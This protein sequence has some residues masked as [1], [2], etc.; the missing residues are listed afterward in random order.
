[1]SRPCFSPLLLSLLL[2]QALSPALAQAPDANPV[3]S[4]D[5]AFGLSVGRET[6]GLYNSGSVRGF[7][8]SAAG[9]LRIDG[10]YFDQVWGLS[11]RV[12]TAT[13]IRVGL[14]AQGFAFP[15]PT[16]I[17]DY[18]LRRPTASPSVALSAGVDDFGSSYLDVDASTPLS[19]ELAAT[20]GLSVSRTG[21]FNGTKG[22]GWTGGLGLW[23]RPS[24]STE[25]GVFASRARAY[26]D[27][28][29]P[30]LIPVGPQL[31]PR[32]RPFQFSGPSWADYEGVGINRGVLLRQRLSPSWA[33]RAGL[34]RSEERGQSSYSH[35]LLDVQADGSG[36]RLIVA[37]PP[38]LVAATSGEIRAVGNWAGAALQHQLQLSVNG[39][40]R[41]RRN[42]GSD[43]RDFGAA[44]IGHDFEPLEPNWAFGPQTQDAVRQWTAGSSYQLRWR[45][46]AEV[47]LGLQQTHYRKAVERPSTARVSTQDAPLLFNLSGAWYFNEAIALYA[48]STRGLEESGTAPDNASNRRQALPAIRTRQVDAG[49]RWQLQPQLKLVAGL[50]EVRKPYLNLDASNTFT[51]LGEVRHRGAELSLSG[52]LTPQLHLVAGAVLMQPRVEGEAVRLGRVGPR[53]V[54]QPE[55]NLRLNLSWQPRD[56]G[57]ASLDFGASHTSELPATRDNR[58]NIPGI[59]V[60]DAGLRWPLRWGE[61][62]VSARFAVSNLFNQRGFEL[63]GSGAYA[64]RPGRQASLSLS[65]AF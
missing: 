2:A 33:L 41:D 20:A 59:T 5:D 57:G 43:S 31:P 53:P 42:G 56:W 23:W 13:T 16:G 25:L 8:P 60:M 55:R 37:D 49:L 45:R 10:L 39:R 44:R 28:F 18:A 46:Q 35:L 47:L 9:N 4:A 17:V 15:A 22:K 26:D 65:T 30:V 64:E 1:M 6:I 62:P 63:R 21:Y 40:A 12:R 7:S 54:G 27:E 52:A 51:Q 19:K 61:Q 36:R 48:G 29:S 11:G 38:S 14:S 34:F 24:A 32:S 3:M 58:V 50:F